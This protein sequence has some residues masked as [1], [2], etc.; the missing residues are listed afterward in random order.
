MPCEVHDAG[1]LQPR[2]PH[3]GLEVAVRGSAVWVELVGAEQRARQLLR[4]SLRVE[5]GVG[6]ASQE[7]RRDPRWRVC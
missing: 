6:S 1:V 2:A 4:L 7:E 5:A 3:L